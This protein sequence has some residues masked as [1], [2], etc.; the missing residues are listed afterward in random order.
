[1]AEYNSHVKETGKARFLRRSGS[2]QS[3]DLKQKHNRHWD[4]SVSTDTLSQNRSSIH[5]QSNE[6]HYHRES[7]EAPLRLSSKFANP[8][9]NKQVIKLL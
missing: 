9:Q 5:E 7:V 1:M 4:S 2:V 8:D 3:V 6:L